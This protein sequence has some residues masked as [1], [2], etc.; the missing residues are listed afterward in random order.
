M[1]E[2]YGQAIVTEHYFP[3]PTSVRFSHITMKARVCRP[4]KISTQVRFVNFVN[5]RCIYSST[6]LLCLSL[7]GYSSTTGCVQ[8]QTAHEQN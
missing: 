6:W 2:T 8:Y 1:S 3:P 4:L 5:P 7:C